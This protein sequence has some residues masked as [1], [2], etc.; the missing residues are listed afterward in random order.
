MIPDSGAAASLDY[1]VH[2][3][4]GRY[5]AVP[6]LARPTR[7]LLLDGAFRGSLYIGLKLIVS[8]CFVH[9]ILFLILWPERH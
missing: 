3:A 1:A 4:V 2:C 5:A 6:E 8:L 9:L 7:K